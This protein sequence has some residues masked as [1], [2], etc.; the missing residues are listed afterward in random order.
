MQRLFIISICLYWITYL[1]PFAEGV[2]GYELE[3]K[4]WNDMLSG[5]VPNMKL[6]TLWS[7]RWL[8]NVVIFGLWWLR[9]PEVQ[10]WMMLYTDKTLLDKLMLAFLVLLVLY[11]FVFESFLWEWGGLLWAI[12][13]IITVFTY[14]V[15][16][17]MKP[18]DLHFSLEEHFVE[19]K[20]EE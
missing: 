4:M 20:E 6:A 14:Q 15:L 13:A 16:D 1:L 18:E 7:F 3:L 19:L 10:R 8:T 9:V 17:N 5:D 12:S 2:F 11:P